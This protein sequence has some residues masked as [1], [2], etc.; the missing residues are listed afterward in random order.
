MEIVL[1]TI[2]KIDHALFS[3]DSVEELSYLIYRYGGIIMHLYI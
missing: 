2:S 3:E 1:G